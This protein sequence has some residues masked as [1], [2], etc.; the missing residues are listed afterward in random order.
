MSMFCWLALAHAA[1]S[2]RPAV[3]KPM[4]Y[5]SKSPDRSCHS[6]HCEVDPQKSA[7]LVPQSLHRWEIPQ[8]WN[9]KPTGTNSSMQPIQGAEWPMLSLL[10]TGTCDFVAT[11]ERLLEWF[12]EVIVDVFID[13][14]D[15]KL[16]TSSRKNRNWK[17]NKFSNLLWTSMNLQFVNHF[18]P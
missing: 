18:K 14:F 11:S 12:Q 3:S 7:I 1:S 13:A 16:F 17:K 6:C 10:F 15:L 5:D 4:D 2:L 9:Y 8:L